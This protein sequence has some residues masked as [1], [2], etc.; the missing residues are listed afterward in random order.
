[1]A[2]RIGI[3]VNENGYPGLAKA[4]KMTPDEVIEEVRASGLRGRGG[5]GYATGDKWRACRDEPGDEKFFVCNAHEGD[6]GALS[7][8]MIL[9]NDP[10]SV[11]E[12]TTI[13]A[14]AV[15]AAQAY[16]Y[17]R[18][19]AGP[20]VERLK[21]ALQQMEEHGFAG[22]NI[23]GSGFDLRIAV[24][25]GPA[26]FV[27]GE[28]TAMI[29]ALEGKRPVPYQRPPFPTACGLHG[30][31]TGV[32]NIETLANV[33]AIFREGTDPFTAHGNERSRGTKLFTLAGRVARPGVVEVPLGTTLREVVF[34]IGGGVADGKSFKAAL[35][36]G[37]TGGF[38]PAGLLDTPLDFESLAAAGAIV[39]SGSIVVFDADTRMVEAA[40]QCV[41]FAQSESCGLCVLCR[42]G[43]WQMLQI[44]KDLA[45]GGG[46]RE[47]LELLRELGEG[48]RQGSLCFLGKTAPNPVLTWLDHFHDEYDQ[49]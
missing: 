41:S 25:E 26:D 2:R 16:V 9:E 29:R 12:G 13:G 43:T 20:A 34:D 28:E 31:P 49:A 40:E 35:V 23:L 3:R 22:D 18:E 32:N 10:H 36:G 44:L 8:R 5:A 33:S 19:D 38:L 4:L 42:E 1:M 15:G 27:C 21:A 7:G 14:Y 48:V 24:K 37:P 45:E 6:P 47:D 17:V 11:L 39:G 46:K 30:K